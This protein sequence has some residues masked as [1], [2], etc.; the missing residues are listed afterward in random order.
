MRKK[1][2]KLFR[3]AFFREIVCHFRSIN[4]IKLVPDLT[5]FLDDVILFAIFDECFAF[6]RKNITPISQYRFRT[7]TLNYLET[8][9]QRIRNV[10]LNPDTQ[11]MIRD[12]FTSNESSIFDSILDSPIG[13]NMVEKSTIEELRETANKIFEGKNA[14][15]NVLPPKYSGI[16]FT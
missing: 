1:E 12:L 15:K 8:Y 14:P 4:F 13:Q 9:S 5:N 11:D 2:W 10:L 3:R 6:S 7:L 16:D